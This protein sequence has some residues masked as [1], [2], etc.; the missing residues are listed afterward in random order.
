MKKILI[1]YGL[2]MFTLIASVTFVA[3]PVHPSSLM[4]IMSALLH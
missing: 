2:V 1:V 4:T 3:E